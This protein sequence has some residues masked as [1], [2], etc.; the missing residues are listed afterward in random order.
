ML[1]IATLSDWAPFARPFLPLVYWPTSFWRQPCLTG[2]GAP[3][4]LIWL[5][6]HHHRCADLPLSEGMLFTINSEGNLSRGFVAQKKRATKSQ[7]LN[8]IYLLV[9]GRL[10]L[11]DWIGWQLEASH[12]RSAPDSCSQL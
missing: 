7:Q 8:Y 5:L 11:R 1:F 6:T 4:F 10:Q 9:P 12:S 3:F 2:R